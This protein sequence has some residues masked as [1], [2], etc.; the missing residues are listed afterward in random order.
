[1]HALRG[2]T[3]ATATGFVRF[4]VAVPAGS[5]ARWTSL[6]TPYAGVA[7]LCCVAGGEQRADSVR[8][9]LRT[10]DGDDL[11]CIL[12]HDAARPFVPVEVVER[13]VAA[14]LAGDP[15]VIPVVPVTDT[16]KRVDRAGR[17]LETPDRSELVAVQ[18][19]QGFAPDVL[20]RAH[21]A[22]APDATDDAMLV[23]RLGVPVRTVEGSPD[24]IKITRPH[25][26][27]LAE[28]I[29]AERAAR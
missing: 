27:V 16:I 28:A 21:A 5:E 25:D 2:L 17:V 19:P 4:T 26:L 1:M 29:L 15:A 6:L 9:A 11:D 12:V 13:V 23:E 22:P 24:S 18:T 8:A 10:L 14:V 20:R 7:E 3:E